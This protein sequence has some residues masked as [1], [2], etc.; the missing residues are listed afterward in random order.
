MS[1]QTFEK[2][3]TAI[4]GLINQIRAENILKNIQPV[5]ISPKTC[6]RRS[7]LNARTRREVSSFVAGLNANAN[8]LDNLTRG[9]EYLVKSTNDQ[10]IGDQLIGYTDVTKRLEAMN[11]RLIR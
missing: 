7:T 8:K 11:A 3:E 5:K 1:G 10:L 2:K 9:V 4:E 6:K